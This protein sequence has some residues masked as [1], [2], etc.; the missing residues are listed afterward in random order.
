[1]TDQCER[2]EASRSAM[3]QGGRSKRAERRTDEEDCLPGQY[4]A[5][6]VG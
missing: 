6:T 5:P 3:I 2:G 1:M 4:A